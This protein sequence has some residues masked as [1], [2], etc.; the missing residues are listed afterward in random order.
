[1]NEVE[2]AMLLRETEAQNFYNGVLQL[3]TALATMATEM[4]KAANFNGVKMPPY[5]VANLYQKYYAVE[6]ATK[7]LKRFMVNVTTV[8][9]YVEDSFNE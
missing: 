3:R 7:L 8:D 9:K 5:M 6:T 2:L 1:M 4:E